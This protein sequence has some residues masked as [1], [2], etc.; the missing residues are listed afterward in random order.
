[1]PNKEVITQKCTTC[2]TVKPLTEFH[3]NCTHPHGRLQMCAVCRNAREQSKNKITM[4]I[5]WISPRQAKAWLKNNNPNNR[6][7]NET[8]AK[9]YGSLMKNKKWMFN[10]DTI[11]FDTNGNILDCQH[12]LEACIDA[13]TSFQV[14]VVRG[15]DPS[16]F[17]TIDNG[18]VRTTAH[19]FHVA[20]IPNSNK[21]AA[22]TN[23][24]RALDLKSLGELS[25]NKNKFSDVLLDYYDN[26]KSILSNVPFSR[27]DGFNDRA[28]HGAQAYLLKHYDTDAVNTFFIRFKDGLNTTRTQA[29]KL[30]DWGIR[31][32]SLKDTKNRSMPDQLNLIITAFIN[33]VS[34]KN[35]KT[36]KP[37][38]TFPFL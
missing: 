5:E 14:I 37:S 25:H 35:P 29:V 22:C 17:S 2:R 9:F 28:C 21:A 6:P 3:E 31:N 7:L 23:V 26:N 20:K 24:L 16:V 18:R 27:Y 1:M 11:R 8:D 38:T 19:T 13:N 4:N 34:N 30:R 15:L 32:N 10:G 36:I 33:S 12:R